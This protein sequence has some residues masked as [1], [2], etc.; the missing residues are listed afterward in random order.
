MH[1]ETKSYKIFKFFN[2]LFMLLIMTVMI[3][4]YLNTLAKALND[5]SNTALGGITIFPRKLTLDNFATLLKNSQIKSAAIISVVRVLCA[6]VFSL[7][8]Q[9]SAAYGFTKKNLLGRSKLLVFLI[10]PMFFTGGLIPTYL[11]YSKIGF[12]NNFLVY[13]IPHAFSLYN[14]VIIRTYINTLPES[15]EES[16]KLDGAN[17]F[18]VFYKIILPLCTPI[19]ATI[20]LWTAVGQ[21]NDWTTTLYFITKQKLFT[22][23]YVLMQVLKETER[24]QKLIQQAALEGQEL[25]LEIKTTPEALQSAQII[26]TTIPIIMV[27]PFLQKYFIKGV[28]LGAVKD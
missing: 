22:L 15:L 12:L 17:E 24:I 14:M 23:Q 9:F 5:A 1:Y 3:Y 19:L 27:Y 25:H 2:I 28:T 16:A 20:A 4:P 10:I 26:L 7:I 11:L 21:W 8:I 13:V 18:V 6:V